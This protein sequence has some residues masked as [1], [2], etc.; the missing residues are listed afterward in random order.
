[1]NNTICE[2]F[3]GIWIR[4]FGFRES[5]GKTYGNYPKRLIEREKSEMYHM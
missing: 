5:F 3:S 1:M 2:K 4:G